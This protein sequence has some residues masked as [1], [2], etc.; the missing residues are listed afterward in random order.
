MSVATM[1]NTLE[2]CG[3]KRVKREWSRCPV[4]RFRF[5][6]RWSVDANGKKCRAAT[7]SLSCARQLTR[8][9]QRGGYTAENPPA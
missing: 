2:N 3:P 1:Y 6:A 8:D 7:C 5:F 4:C 9:R